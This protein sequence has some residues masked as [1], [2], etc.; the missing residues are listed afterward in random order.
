MISSGETTLVKNIISCDECGWPINI[1]QDCP[2]IVCDACD[3]AYKLRLETSISSLL[4]FDRG[5]IP[6]H[7]YE[8]NGNI[9]LGRDEKGYLKIWSEKIEAIQEHVPIWSLYISRKHA[10]IKVE[11]ENKLIEKDDTKEIIGRLKCFIED[12]SLNGT[13]IN[14]M[15]LRRGEFKELKNND[16]IT[17]APSSDRYVTITF[18]EKVE[19]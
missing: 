2:E 15:N 4:I 8:I 19:I 12:I 5:H 11:K 1:A 17:L 16:K 9:L 18:K 6:P 7:T 14:G 3:Y 10:R 13:Q